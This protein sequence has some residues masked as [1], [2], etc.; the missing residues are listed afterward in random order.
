MTD[1]EKDIARDIG[2]FFKSNGWTEESFKQLGITDVALKEDTIK[3]RLA[4]PGLLIGKRGV[5]VE[6][7]KEHL[8]KRLKRV[9]KIHIVEN[10]INSYLLC[11]Y[12]VERY[13]G[14]DEFW[15][16]EHETFA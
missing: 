8:E 9:I 15:A 11:T 5:T 10:D 13:L 4:R 1:M 12:A 3:I 14:S 7:L 16:A 6:S 2:F